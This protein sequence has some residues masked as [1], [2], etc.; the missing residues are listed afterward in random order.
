MRSKDAA[1]AAALARN[2]RRRC[3]NSAKSLNPLTVTPAQHHMESVACEVKKETI[4]KLMH[5]SL[6]LAK[7]KSLAT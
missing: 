1:S 3:A 7:V 5:A 6:T 4:L 2:C